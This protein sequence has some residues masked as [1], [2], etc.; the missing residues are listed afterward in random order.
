M[1]PTAVRNLR[2]SVSRSSV[3]RLCSSLA[4][5][6]LFVGCG[7]SGSPEFR[8]DMVAIAEKQI[9]AEQTQ[10]VANILDAMFGTPDEPFVLPETGLDASLVKMSAGPTA[11]DQ[12]GRET[13]LYRRHCAHCH[14]TSGDG[15]GPTAMLL[16]PYPRDYR[17]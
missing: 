5:L 4:L 3:T 17:Q 13:G 1:N 15:M 6:S 10:E 16:N 8:L 12:F 11:S 14:G 9:P 7:Q 2:T